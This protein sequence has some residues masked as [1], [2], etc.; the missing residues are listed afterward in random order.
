MAK[1]FSYSASAVVTFIST[2]LITC[3][4]GEWGTR[5]T[6]PF[7]LGI[8]D[9]MRNPDKKMC[10]VH[11]APL[12]KDR[13]KVVTSGY[14]GGSWNSDEYFPYANK[15]FD[16]YREERSRNVA[17]I[18]FCPRCRETYEQCRQKL[19]GSDWS[20]QVERMEKLIQEGS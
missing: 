1:C 6:T 15:W 9:T 4:I 8:A 13:V 7:N 14:L 10:E 20:D 3:T 11:N 2:L 18:L 17:F 19:K 12:C 16:T 5:F